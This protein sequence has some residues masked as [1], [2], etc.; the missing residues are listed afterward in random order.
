MY[1]VEEVE[2]IFQGDATFPVIEVDRD[3]GEA[4]GGFPEEAHAGDQS[5]EKLLIVEQV[6]YKDQDDSFVV[7]I[8]LKEPGGETPGGSNQDFPY[9]EECLISGSMAQ[10]VDTPDGQKSEKQS[11][12]DVLITEIDR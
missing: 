6:E 8:G 12:K 3:E 5:A 1:R 7:V 2:K 9:P 11:K 10:G 4:G